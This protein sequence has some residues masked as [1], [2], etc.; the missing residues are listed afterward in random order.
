VTV[1]IALQAVAPSVS[2]LADLIAPWAPSFAARL[3]APAAQAPG[4]ARLK[5]TL[6]LD[7]DAKAADRASARASLELTAPQLKGTATLRAS[8]KHEAIHAMKI[9][10]LAK[11]PLNLAIDASAGNGA[12]L[13]RWLGLDRMLAA[14]EGAAR[15]TGSARGMWDTAWQV[16]AA[17]SAGA[18]TADVH[19][20]VTPTAQKSA[21]LVVKLQGANLA[22]LFG[23]DASG[24]LGQDASLSSRVT[25]DG[26]KIKF[27]DVDATVA[28]T[29]LRGRVGVTLGD[30]GGFDGELG[31]DKLDLPHAFALLIGASARDKGAPLGKNLLEGWRGKIDFQ[32]LRGALPAGLEL[33]PVSG[34]LKSDG[35][36]L[37][38]N[39]HQCHGGVEIEAV[40]GELSIEI[41]CVAVLA[42]GPCDAS[43]NGA[44]ID[45]GLEIVDGD[46][47]GA[48][49]HVAGDMQRLLLLRRCVG[50]PEQPRGKV[51][52]IGGIDLEH[53]LEAVVDIGRC[54]VR[55]AR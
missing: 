49:M 54:I 5:L 46:A 7:K 48:K 9:D 26:D 39:A 37:A 15:L 43:G 38:I 1:N 53:A 41:G 17:L 18:L 51:A 36:S 30:N 3:N 4:A 50:A 20:D 28:G 12:T 8:P 47:I 24:S 32:A 27:G 40:G 29:R 19:G 31:M 44:A 16:K 25:R 33:Q 55:M 11:T 35:Q 52:G 10:A 42:R 2:D 6:D 14:G 13:L 34:V 21:D 22:P 45:V 23:L